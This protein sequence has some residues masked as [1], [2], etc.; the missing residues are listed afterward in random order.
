MYPD[1]I[2]YEGDDGENNFVP[3]PPLQQTDATEEGGGGAQDGEGE[4]G[5]GEQTA[6]AAGRARKRRKRASTTLVGEYVESRAHM[7]ENL[8]VET[9]QM[10]KEVLQIEKAAAEEYKKAREEERQHNIKMHQI[11]EEKARKLM[12]IELEIAD[13]RLREAKAKAEKA[14]SIF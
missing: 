2:I 8:R 12:Q 13:C 7:E 14:E 3:S 5:E 11:E 10:R 4:A 9:H 6:P 1:T